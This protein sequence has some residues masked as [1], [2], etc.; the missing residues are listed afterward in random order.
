[1]AAKVR[2]KIKLPKTKPTKFNK[3]AEKKKKEVKK[4]VKGGEVEGFEWDQ[5]VGEASVEFEG[6]KGEVMGGVG[7]VKPTRVLADY[8]CVREYIA[9]RFLFIYLSSEF[10]FSYNRSSK[11]KGSKHTLKSTSPSQFLPFKLIW[12]LSVC[13]LISSIWSP[14]FLR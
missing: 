8:D 3:V 12:E 9:H 6:L 14:L 5:K 10:V 11:K 4:E 1:M 13:H 2:E 7:E